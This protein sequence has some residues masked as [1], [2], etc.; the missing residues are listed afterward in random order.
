MGKFRIDWGLNV[1]NVITFGVMLLGAII[2]NE[3]RLAMF[4]RRSSHLENVVATLV[5][6]QKQHSVAMKEAALAS[7]Q[8]QIVVAQ[9]VVKVESLYKK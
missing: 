6:S 9:L 5:E 1:A 4:E 3:R 8:L 2:A 7:A